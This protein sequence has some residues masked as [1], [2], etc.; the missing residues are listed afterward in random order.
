MVT[1]PSSH[2]QSEPSRSGDVPHHHREIAESFGIDA[3]RYDRVRPHYPVAVAEAVMEGL[4]GREVLDV[5]IG[6]GISALSFRELGAEVT[7]VEVDPRMAE[8]ARRRNFTVD[9]ARFEDWESGG[10]R[11]DAV[12]SGQTWHWIDPRAGAAKAAS[13]LRPSGRLALFWN[14]ADPAPDIASA[15][16][17]VYRGVDTGLPF[18]PWA[19]PALA[20]HD[21]ITA[22]AIDG[23]DSTSAFE[24]PCRLSIDW[25]TEITREEWN[26]H[27]PTMGGHNRIAGDQLSQ[28]LDGLGQVIDDH[29]GSFT[30][31]YS[32]V[33]TLA[34][35]GPGVSCESQQSRT[36]SAAG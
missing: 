36:D 30:M 29:G 8:F 28:L 16:A 14:V 35:L 17:E 3:D 26:E 33:V 15:F 4:Q 9:V 13:L 5:G 18:T 27:V 25:H 19:E 32:T 22:A 23:I 21:A 6:T 10:R 11:F 2:P 12:I 24:K 31:R 1:L 34:D 20:G 7:G